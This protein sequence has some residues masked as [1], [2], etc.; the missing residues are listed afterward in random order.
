VV[1]GLDGRSMVRIDKLKATPAEFP[2]AAGVPSK[3]P[4]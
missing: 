4:L 1:A 2:R 3:R